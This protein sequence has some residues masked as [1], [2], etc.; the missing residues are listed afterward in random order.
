[1]LNREDKI[2]K[3]FSDGLSNF[4][5]A[6][7]AV[8]WDNISAT[9]GYRK[10]KTRALWWWT[11]SGAASLIIAFVTG[12]YLSNKTIDDGKLSAEIEV[13]KNKQIE[14]I[15]INRPIENNDIIPL[16][17]E[18]TK[19][20]VAS[21]IDK[22]KIESDSELRLS[23]Q[24]FETIIASR[25]NIEVIELLTSETIG[26]HYHSINNF[27]L[28]Q[29]ENRIGELDR[30][31]IE[32]NLLAMNNDNQSNSEKGKWLMGIQASPVYRFEQ[33]GSGEKVYSNGSENVQQSGTSSYKPNLTGGLS[34]SYEAGNKLAIISG[35]NYNEVSQNSGKIGVDFTANNWF[36]S[37]DYA[38]FAPENEIAESVESSSSNNLIL[39]TNVGSANVVLPKGAEVAADSRLNSSFAD[40]VQTYD[41][42]QAAGYV[43]VPLLLKYK[44]V[45]KRFGIHLLGG[46]NTNILVTNNVKLINNGEVVANSNV[47]NLSPITYSSSLGMGMNYNISERFRINVDPMFKIQLN[48]LNTQSNFNARPYAFG[49]YSGITY[50]F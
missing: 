28:V 42:E 7:P 32:A 37:K 48:S 43:E 21:K 11:M 14:N 34:V 15:V 10:R 12:W 35:V 30:K 9:M 46:V 49:V 31:I 47:E 19:S 23:K 39:N 4:E 17:K 13:L 1:M 22:S 40:L 16:D 25:S 26:L 36:A 38:D 44:L 3:M 45:D 27:E 24:V 29:D 18:E 41:F 8:V 5:V 50:Q 2:D 20:L 6:P 33:S